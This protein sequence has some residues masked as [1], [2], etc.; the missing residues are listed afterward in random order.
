MSLVSL[1][2]FES[3][4][5]GVGD[6]AKWTQTIALLEIVHAA[7]GVVRA[8]ILTTGMQVAS[9]LLLV[10]PVIDVFPALATSPA[11]SS[12]LVA[13]SVTEVV[14]YSYFVLNLSGYQPALVTWLRYNTFYILYPTGISSECYLIYKAIEPAR[15]LRPEFAWALQAILLIYVP[16]SYILF[17]H[18]MAQRRKVMRG[19]GKQVQK[20]A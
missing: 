11:Y 16:G 18:M 7:A 13:W 19:K 20:S 10:W 12:M 4:Y 14:R 3:T 9:R 17:T 1:T 8:P 5:A 6:F 2:G 15:A